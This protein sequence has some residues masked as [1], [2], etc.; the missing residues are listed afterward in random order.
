MK[1][2]KHT[3][4][5]FAYPAYAD[6][7]VIEVYRNGKLVQKQILSND[8]PQLFFYAENESTAAERS[9]GLSAEEAQ[10]AYLERATRYIANTTYLFLHNLSLLDLDA[11]KA[12]FS[13]MKDNTTP[14]GNNAL[15]N[16]DIKFL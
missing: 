15:S 7:E 10:A 3:K 13:D 5:A 14:E 8:T 6:T 9:K 4:K 12:V 11:A 16:Y 1:T 2:K